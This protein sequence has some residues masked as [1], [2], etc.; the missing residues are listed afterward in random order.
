MH[1]TLHTLQTLSLRQKHEMWEESEWIRSV[2]WTMWSH[3]V[4]S[5]WKS[6]LSLTSEWRRQN[7]SG[8]YWIWAW[9]SVARTKLHTLI[10]PSPFPLEFWGVV[11]LFNLRLE[12]CPAISIPVRS[13]SQFHR[14]WFPLNKEN[15]REVVQI[16]VGAPH[17]SCQSSRKRICQYI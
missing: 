4:L 1:D 8:Q 16:E 7:S 2:K 3:C 17:L 5:I 13:T 10:P 6:S 9:L 15:H 14:Q 12:C 11:E